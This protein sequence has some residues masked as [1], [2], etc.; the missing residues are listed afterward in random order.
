MTVKTILHP[1]VYADAEASG[2]DM[3][4]YVASRPIIDI[5]TLRRLAAEFLENE[6]RQDIYDILMEAAANMKDLC[7]QIDGCIKVAADALSRLKILE[8]QTR[9]P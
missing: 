9:T 4:G 8:E 1:R 5:P 7:D 6:N 2:R 3:G